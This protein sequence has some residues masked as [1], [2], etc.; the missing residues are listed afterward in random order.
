M[1]GSVAEVIM[2]LLMAVYYAG[3]KFVKLFLPQAMFEKDI[4]GQ[5]VLV[6]G[7]GSGI[8]RLMCLRFARLGATVVTWDVNKTGNEET[9]A[10]VKREGNK[11]TAFTVD[12][13]KREDIYK[14]A[15]ETKNKVGPVSIL[16]NNAGIVSGTALL[17][18]SDEK[19]I[20]TF[21]VNI[22]AHFWTIKAFLPDM[23]S[24]RQGHL[25]NVA[26]LAGHSGTN[27]LVDYCASKFAA[28]G[29]DEALRVELFVQGHSDYVKT[30]VICPY[31]ISTGMFAGVQSKIIP[32][33]EPEFV[34][35]SVVSGVLTNREVVLLPW[36]SFLLIALKA[37]MTEPAFMRLSAAFG[38]NCSMDQFEGRK[39]KE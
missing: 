28:V 36:W 12:M 5:V 18:T 20:R 10:L 32:I 22:M 26:S 1:A 7:G 16:V 4:N 33:L 39:K 37:V 35:D 15:E 30:T 9:V 13:T 6:T 14:M 3:E 11:A 2:G 29:L 21:D 19:I 27:K 8:G 38:F 24:N 23:I 25:V 34:A 17:D 31:Y